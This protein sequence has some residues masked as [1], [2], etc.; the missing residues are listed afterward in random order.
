MNTRMKPQDRAVAWRISTVVAPSLFVLV[1]SCGDPAARDTEPTS[2][3]VP[4]PDVSPSGSNSVTPT[5]PLPGTPVEPAPTASGPTVTG[6]TVSGPTVTPGSTS[7]APT[8]GETSTGE[9]SVSAPSGTSAEPVPSDVVTLA[10]LDEILW[11]KCGL[12][13]CHVQPPH[14]VP[15]TLSG[16]ESATLH[17]HLTSYAAKNCQGGTL[18]VPGNAAESVLIKVVTG[19]C[20]GFTMPPDPSYD[21]FTEEELA[22]VTAW[23]NAGAPNQ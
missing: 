3:S 11:Q 13:I 4:W 8:S 17:A 7:T 5:G 21:S 19:A 16:S 2:S 6:P 9:T 1:A 15:P 10:E 22:K 12:G 14:G 20:G 18:V 23:I